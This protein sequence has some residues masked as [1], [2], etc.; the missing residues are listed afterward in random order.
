MK[1]NFSTTEYILQGLE[2]D[3]AIQRSE[4]KMK[5]VFFG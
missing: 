2:S 4:V 1:S 3:G 5:K